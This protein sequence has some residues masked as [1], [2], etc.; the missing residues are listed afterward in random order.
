MELLYNIL[1]NPFVEMVSLPDFFLQVIWV[2]GLS[3]ILMAVL[4]RLPRWAIALFAFA[5]TSVSGYALAYSLLI[6]L[7]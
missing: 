7:S 4:I 5:C 3:M 6:Y 1:I 2:I